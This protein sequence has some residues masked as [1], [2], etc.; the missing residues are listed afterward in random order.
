MTSQSFEMMGY[1]C[2]IVYLFNVAL[3]HIDVQL[4]LVILCQAGLE[5]IEKTDC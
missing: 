3:V 2:S 5:K 1:L 4:N